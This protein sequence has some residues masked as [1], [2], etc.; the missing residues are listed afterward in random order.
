MIKRLAR[1]L[2]AL[3][4][5]GGSVWVAVCLLFIATHPTLEFTPEVLARPAVSLPAGFL[6]GTATSAHQIE[7]G[8]DNDWTRFESVPG[9][10]EGGDSSAVTVDHWN[11]MTEDV[12]LMEA[13]GANAYRFSIEWSRVEPEE[14]AWNEEAW[15]RYEDLV[16]RLREAGLTPMVTLLHFTLPNWIADRGGVT[17]RDF[18]ERFARFASEAGRRL[19]AGVDLWC[20]I[21]EPNVQ[22]FMGY[23]AGEWPPLETSPARAA[24]AWVGLLRAHAAAAKALRAVDPEAKIGIAQNQMVLQP[25]W[26]F[27][28]PDWLAV[29]FVDQAWNWASYDAIRDGHVRFR[30]PGASIDEPMP[31]LVGSADYFGLNYYFRYFVHAVPGAPQGVAMRPGPGMQSELGGDPP[32]GDSYPEGLVLLMR[33]AWSRYGLPI[34]VTEAGI[35]DERGVMRGPLIRAHV[36]AI[37]WARAEGIPVQGYLHWTLMDNFEWDKG[38]R[39]RFGLHRVDP[40]TLERTPAGGAHEFAALAPPQ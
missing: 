30:L 5:I 3:L 15:A 10:I 4:A 7:G 24:A 28:L 38:Y 26:R 35:A 9:N 6:W 14:G 39:P 32:P 12:A 18:P 40:E 16:R 31:D 8:N 36:E 21:N 23:M 1:W 37:Q 25:E 17:A 22:M 19:G 34:Y 27:W 29:R 13:I 2:V 20:T 11:R 33:E